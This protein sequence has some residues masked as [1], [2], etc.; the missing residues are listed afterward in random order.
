M[1]TFCPLFGS[2]HF[3]GLTAWTY[4]EPT[5]AAN[6]ISVSGGWQN[7]TIDQNSVPPQ[8]F[9]QYYNLKKARD[10][11]QTISKKGGWEMI[12]CD[13]QTILKLGSIE[14]TVTAVRKRLFAEGYLNSDSQSAVFDEELL[15]ALNRYKN[16]HNQPNDSII[17]QAVITS[18]NIPVAERINTIEV[19]LE[20]ARLVT[21]DKSGHYIAVNI[22]AFKLYYFREGKLVLDSKVVVGKEATKT[23]VFNSVMDQIIFSPYWNIPNSIVQKEILPSIRKNPKKFSQMRLE[24]HNG[25]LRQKP[26]PGNALGLVKF[27]FP[28]SN[29]IY[30]HDTPLKDYFK[31]EKRTFSH[32]CIR[33][34]KACELAVNIMEYDF[35][36][37]EA[38]TT[39]AMASGKEEVHKLLT[40]I[41][42]YIAY[43]TAWADDDGN[44]AFYADIYGHDVASAEGKL[45]KK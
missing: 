4:L 14:P 3:N 40:K 38:Q 8:E 5:C 33:V 2:A 23:V 13:T 37:T 43:F 36:W 24:W 16:R 31:A 11:Y 28:N 30:L 6:E 32:G 10:K 39:K 22:P 41:P 17:S 19:N 45:L 20:R 27:V 15:Y 34:E 21:P 18:M 26:G 12:R 35:G 42:V 25:K 29:N 1:L 44:V 7:L 9:K